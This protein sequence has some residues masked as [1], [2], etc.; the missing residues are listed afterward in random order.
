[1]K[2]ENVKSK[3]GV[4]C[5][6]RARKYAAKVGELAQLG[7]EDMKN[8]EAAYLEDCHKWEQRF[9]EGIKR[10]ADRHKTIPDTPVEAPAEEP[11]AVEPVTE[12]DPGAPTPEPEKEP[13]ATS[14]P[15]PDYS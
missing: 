14:E 6:E 10:Y 11:V 8:L 2:N 9:R 3:I 12:C 5:E 15:P 4:A 13:G 1:M 7:D